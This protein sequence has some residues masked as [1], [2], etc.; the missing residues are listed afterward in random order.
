MYERVGASRCSVHCKG[1]DAK[2]GEE[3]TRQVNQPTRSRLKESILVQATTMRESVTVAI[4]PCATF[5]HSDL[6]KPD[7]AMGSQ[8]DPGTK[9]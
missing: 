9:T 7:E 8:Q 4:A 2:V 1:V 3:T 5:F 6:L